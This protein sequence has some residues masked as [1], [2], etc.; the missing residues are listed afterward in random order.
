MTKKIAEADAQ[1]QVDAAVEVATEKPAP[2]PEVEPE[3]VTPR[4]WD[5]LESKLISFQGQLTWINKGD[6]IDAAGYGTDG[7]QKLIDQG[8]KLKPVE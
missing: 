5:V 8:L 1:E 6:Q 2:A 3:K 7:I 4:L